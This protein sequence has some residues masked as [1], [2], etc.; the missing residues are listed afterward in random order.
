M[1]Y[2][3]MGVDVSMISKLAKKERDSIITENNTWVGVE[4]GK[5]FVKKT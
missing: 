5:T 1:R 2:N 4:L 3:F